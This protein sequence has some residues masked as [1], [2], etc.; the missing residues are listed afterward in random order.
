MEPGPGLSRQRVRARR[1]RATWAA[2]ASR[3]PA[4]RC[5]RMRCCWRLGRTRCCARRCARTAPRSREAPLTTFLRTLKQGSSR[6]RSVLLAF[7]CMCACVVSETDVRQAWSR[8]I[9]DVDVHRCINTM[10]KGLEAGLTL[11]EG[12]A[13]MWRKGVALTWRLPASAGEAQS[14]KPC[15]CSLLRQRCSSV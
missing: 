14:G 2:C 5:R 11:R 15:P 4:R 8:F 9:N 6:Q 7:C 1:C 10:K 12:V 3:R 13:A